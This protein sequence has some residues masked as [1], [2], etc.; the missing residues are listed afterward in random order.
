[1]ISP[2]TYV[3]ALLALVAATA[4]ADVAYLQIP[5]VQGTST[6]VGRTGWFEIIQHT[7][8]LAPPVI[9][10]DKKTTFNACTA[11]IEARLIPATPT[12]AA[13]LGT[14]VGDVRIEVDN[15]AGTISRAVLR[16][17]VIGQLVTQLANGGTMVEKITVKFSQIDLEQRAQKPDG[18][19]GPPVNGS[20]V[21]ASAP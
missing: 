13:L 7:I 15:A 10:T 12:V 1:M 19:L 11:V 9:S 16:A 14:T 8:E 2:R 6:Q 5:G 3:A 17:A 21:C 18:S 20:F 4:S